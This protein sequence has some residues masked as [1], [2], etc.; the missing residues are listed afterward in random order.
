[1]ASEAA[2]VERLRAI[3]AS[4]ASGELGVELDIGDD[5]AVLSGS[6]ARQVLSVDAH[7]EGVHFRRD[8]LSPREI[9]ARAAAAALSDLAAMGARPR[10]VL[11][12]LGLPRSVT[13]AELEDLALGVREACDEAGARV[14][15]GNLSRASE[16]SIHTTVVGSLEGQ[17]LTR[18]GARV[19]HGVFVTGTVGAA[20]L[21][22]AALEA[23]RRSEPL[24]APFV[25]RWTRP[26]PRLSEGLALCEVA[27]ALIDVSDGLVV[28][29][30][31]I[32]RASGVALQLEARTLPLAP[33]FAEACAALGREP[34]A[35]ALGGGEDYELAFTAP[36]S[37]GAARLATAIGVVLDGTPGVDVRGHDGR[38][39]ETRGFD[40]FG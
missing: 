14:V 7:V 4:G 12:S 39:L 36:L 6:S 26:R 33:G 32:A 19:G 11:L 24:L 28:D 5:A 29:L 20:A 38:A 31:R 27:S 13:D 22:L 8:W 10:V 35:L 18:A 2:R 17:A 34:L 37:S 1:M 21:G 15:G 30:E 23:G 25:T 40:H 9:G 16:L 3:F